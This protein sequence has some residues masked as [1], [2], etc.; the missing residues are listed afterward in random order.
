MIAEA[1]SDFESEVRVDVA[2]AHCAQ[3]VPPGLIDA[4]VAEQFCCAG[5]RAVYDTIR[6]CGLDSYYRLPHATAAAALKPANPSTDSCAA[7]DA[8]TFDALHVTA[9][10][11]GTR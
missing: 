10:A 6:A 9:N 2:C 3:V 5:C 1:P 4:A 11:D 7:F 8:P